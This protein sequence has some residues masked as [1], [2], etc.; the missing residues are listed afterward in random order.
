MFVPIKDGLIS[1]YSRY[2][3]IQTSVC[4]LK[5]VQWIFFALLSV[6]IPSA[7][8]ETK[9]PTEHIQQRPVPKGVI[10]V[11]EL[12]AKSDHISLMP[13]S[14]DDHVDVVI[15]K[16]TRLEGLQ[17]NAFGYGESNNNNDRCLMVSIYTGIKSKGVNWKQW[18]LCGMSSIL[19]LQ[20]GADHSKKNY[21]IKFVEHRVAVQTMPYYLRSAILGGIIVLQTE[22]GEG[23]LFMGNEGPVWK[24]LPN[25]E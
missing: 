19:A 4:L 10:V 7:F 8:A 11:S 24:E 25:S 12:L 5:L 22:G 16:T 3:G 6:L 20:P 14:Q 13:H 1:I 21:D 18:M 9:I 17:L 15:G 23:I 2:F